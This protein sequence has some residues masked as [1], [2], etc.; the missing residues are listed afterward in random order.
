MIDSWL[1]SLRIKMKPDEW[2][3]KKLLKERGVR[4][5]AGALVENTHGGVVN[6]LSFP[7]VVKVCDSAILHKTDV[8]GVVLNV[9]EKDLSCTIEAMKAK[10][11]GSRILV[12]EMHHFSGIE[13]I[14][15]GL[16]DPTFGPAIMIGAGGILTELYRD[17]TFRLVPLDKAEALRMLQELTVS[18]VLTGYRGSR[19][20]IGEMADIV[21]I[22]GD[23]I[24]ELGSHFNQLD[25]NPMVYTQEGWSALDG[26]LVLNEV[27]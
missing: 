8:G 20:D 21:V 16:V 3:V 4:V 11:P 15:G 18:A 19:M 26:M 9:E 25:I 6:G 17:V 24:T 1:E 27:K 2:E 22:V 13:F 14:L 12:E 23:L 5:P 10:F 7:V